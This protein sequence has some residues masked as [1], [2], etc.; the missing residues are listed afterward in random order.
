MLMRALALCAALGLSGCAG[1][2]IGHRMHLCLGVCLTRFDRVGPAIGIS[3]WAFGLH[4]SPCQI[5]VGGEASYCTALPF[6]D[7]AIIERGSGPDQHVSIQ[8]LLSKVPK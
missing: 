5:N 7:V 6:G 3:S 8:P 4:A 2:P 1:V